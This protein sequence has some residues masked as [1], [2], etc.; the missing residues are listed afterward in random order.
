MD[1][2]FI[3]VKEAG[4]NGANIYAI[5]P[6]GQ[7]ISSFQAF[8]QKHVP[9]YIEELREI[10]TT[11]S[12]Y[13]KYGAREYFFQKKHEGK[14]GDGICA[15]FDEKE[16]HLRLYCI[17]HSENILILG[18]GGVK[19][20]NIRAWQECPI[21]SK[22]VNFLIKVAKDFRKQLKKGIIVIEDNKIIDNRK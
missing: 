18:G 7:T 2:K 22:E 17:R 4:K 14:H 3:H 11:I 1:F 21:L 10:N 16:T 9:T 6:K 20:K 19:P 15:I 13:A 12:S 8:L 5:V